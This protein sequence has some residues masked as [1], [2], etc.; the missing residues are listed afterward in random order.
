MSKRKIIHYDPK[1]KYLAR[2][3]R[4]NSTL[5]EILLWNHLR[6]KKMLGYQFLRQKPLD[7]YI[8]DFF[9]YELMLAIEVDG[10]THD[11]KYEYD[12]KRQKRLESLG[13]RFIRIH[14]IEI[15]QN[16]DGVIQMIEQWIIDHKDDEN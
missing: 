4:N 15:M 16:I 10:V 6:A 14:D 3:L 8:V 1:L 13:I 9:C 5:A 2:N 11:Y 7:K 12:V